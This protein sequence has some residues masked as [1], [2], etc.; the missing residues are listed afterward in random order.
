MRAAAVKHP[1][2]YS[3]DGDPEATEARGISTTRWRS[4]C[5][6]DSEGAE[7]RGLSSI[8]GVWA[9][10]LVISAGIPAV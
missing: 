2:A 1:R 6:I 8:V 3:R 7:V 10:R 5:I 9:S 4:E